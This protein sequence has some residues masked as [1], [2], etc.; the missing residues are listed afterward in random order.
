MWC[1]QSIESS[2]ISLIKSNPQSEAWVSESQ[3]SIC[4]ST[5]TWMKVK[6]PQSAINN[7][8][9]WWS[10]GPALTWGWEVYSLRHSTW[11]QVPKALTKVSPLAPN[12]TILYN[13][14]SHY[15]IMYP[16]LCKSNMPQKRSVQYLSPNYGTASG[17]QLRPWAI[18]LSSQPGPP[19]A[20]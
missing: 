2:I 20:M 1:I 15:T 18:P 7:V 14:T 8:S 16:S 11:S 19:S 12:Y 17:P 9:N 13:T 5:L 3:F 4:C 10:K 6:S